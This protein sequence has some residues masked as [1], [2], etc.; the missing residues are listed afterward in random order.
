MAVFEQGE[1][2]AYQAR[3]LP[4]NEIDADLE[5]VE[6]AE[7]ALRRWRDEMQS[8]QAADNTPSPPVAPAGG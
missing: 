1:N 3:A 6:S 4:Q 7:I 8:G 5:A 2:G